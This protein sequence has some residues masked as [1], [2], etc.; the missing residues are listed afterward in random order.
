MTLAY[1]LEKEKGGFFGLF[2]F[3]FNLG[4]VIGGF[5]TLGINLH[6]DDGATSIHPSTYFTFCGLMVFG[7]IFALVCVQIFV[8]VIEHSQLT[9][10]IFTYPSTVS[11]H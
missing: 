1:A 3:I 6:H 10:R 2:W 7:A 8:N 9:D 11:S 4:G 5:I